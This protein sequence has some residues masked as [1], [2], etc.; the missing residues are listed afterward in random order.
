MLTL[1]S[2]CSKNKQLS[3]DTIS[4]ACGLKKD[5]EVEGLVLDAYGNQL[6]EVR[7]DQR[8]RLIQVLTIV[9]GRDV[10]TNEVG[11]LI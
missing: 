2:L 4:E 6:I 8:N 5:E 3:F 7:I 1:V 11:E 10:R 9:T